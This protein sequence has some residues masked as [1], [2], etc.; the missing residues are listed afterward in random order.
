MEHGQFTSATS[1]K[2][3]THLITEII[4]AN[5]FSGRV[6]ISWASY[7]SMMKWWLLPICKEKDIKGREKPVG[8][9]EGIQWSGDGRHKTC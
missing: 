6:G 8:K 5:S 3:I 9:N 7:L 1:L 4:I 2:K